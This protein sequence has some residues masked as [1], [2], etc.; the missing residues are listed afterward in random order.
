MNKCRFCGHPLNFKFIDLQHSPVSNA[1]IP[2]ERCKAAEVTYPLNVNVCDS[3]FLV[4]TEDYQ[5]S[6]ELFTSDYPYFSSFSKSWLQH[7]SDYVDMMIERFEIDSSSYVVEVASNDGYLLQFFKQQGVKVC[8]IEPTQSTA[9]VAI[10]K[11]IETVVDFFGEDLAARHFADKKA[12]LIIGN[13]VLAHVPDINDFVGGVKIGLAL[14]GICTFEFP[15]LVELIANNQFDTIYHE[16]F[17]YFSFQTVYKIFDTHGLTVFDVQKLKTHGGSLRVFLKHKGDENRMVTSQVNDL[18]NEEKQ[19]G[20]LNR[21]YYKN[22]EQK[23]FTVK[24][25]L[26]EFLI[27][28]KKANKKVA[29]YG[30]AAKGN[31]LLNY[32]GVKGDLIDYCCDANI[33]K[34]G[35][36]MPGSHIS[37]M[38]PDYI[39]EDKPD[40]ILILPWN[41]KDEI[42]SDLSYIRDWGGHFIVAIPKLT[43]I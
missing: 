20:V 5:T 41:L 25:E 36:F 24:L 1:F 13:N 40:Y 37:I 28:A 21:D 22:F 14:D 35:M 12:D 9:D 10:S 42:T 4:Q 26:L 43:I 38:S 17:S 6:S 18:L 39:K 33:H 31:T 30:A 16:H 8:G 23:A 15:H 27:S 3:C 2:M 32:C 19:L 7:S 11:G 29:A 34:Q